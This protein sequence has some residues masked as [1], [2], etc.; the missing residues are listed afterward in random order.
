MIYYIIRETNPTDGR[1]I[2]CLDIQPILFLSKSL[3]SAKRNYWLTKL[4]VACLVWVIKK[5]RYI[6]EAVKKTI[7]FTNYSI[8]KGIVT[9][10]S[11][12]S[13]NSDKLNLRLVR[14]S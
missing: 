14:A 5:I 10:N 6:V 11:L 12:T 8:T 7:V 13:S 4:E 9:A 2:R 1:T 3:T